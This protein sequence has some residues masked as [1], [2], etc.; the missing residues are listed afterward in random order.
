[1]PSRLSP[2]TVVVARGDDY[3]YYYYYDDDA[4]ADADGCNAEEEDED[5]DDDDDEKSRRRRRR[6][7]RRTNDVW[8]LKT[9][10]RHEGWSR[11]RGKDTKMTI[12]EDF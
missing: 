9:M 3:D 11:R 6:R 12:A 10:P 4:N 1:M 5:D 2:L 7:R 8:T